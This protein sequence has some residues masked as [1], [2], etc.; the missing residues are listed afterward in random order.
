MAVREATE[1]TVAAIKFCQSR[2]KVSVLLRR[3]KHVQDVST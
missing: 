1:Y 3:D 2:S